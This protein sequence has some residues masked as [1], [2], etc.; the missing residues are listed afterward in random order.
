[1]ARYRDSFYRIRGAQGP[2]GR[3]ITTA[4]YNLHWIYT[5]CPSLYDWPSVYRQICYCLLGSQNKVIKTRLWASLCPFVHLSTFLHS[6][7]GLMIPFIRAPVLFV[8]KQRLPK[9]RSQCLPR[10]SSGR[11][12]YVGQKHFPSYVFFLS[13]LPFYNNVLGSIS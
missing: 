3:E 1:M 13:T 6:R 8:P 10:N 7:Q 12:P 4:S 9:L 11:K 2:Q 5:K